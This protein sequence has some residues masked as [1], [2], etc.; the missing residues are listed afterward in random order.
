MKIFKKYTYNWWQIGLLKL[1]LLSFGVAIG[2][3]WHEIFS[4]YMRGD[5]CGPVRCVGLQHHSARTKRRVQLSFKSVS[6]GKRQRP[7]CDS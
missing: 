5:P 7:E 4:Q 3:S 2:A 6:S 1:T